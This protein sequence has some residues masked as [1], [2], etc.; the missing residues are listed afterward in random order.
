[1]AIG[2]HNVR[3]RGPMPMPS[4]S[5]SASR[6]SRPSSLTRVAAYPPNRHMR[7]PGPSAFPTRLPSVLNMRAQPSIARNAY[8]L[9]LATL[10]YVHSVTACPIRSQ[11]ALPILRSIAARQ[12][13]RP[14]SHRPATASNTRV[15]RIPAIIAAHR[16]ATQANHDSAAVFKKGAVGNHAGP[17]RHLSD[18]GLISIDDGAQK[19]KKKFP[20]SWPWMRKNGIQGD[21]RGSTPNRPRA[22]S[23]RICAHVRLIR[24]SIVRRGV[25]K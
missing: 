6:W 2:K 9:I 24:Q 5:V 20:R 18:D 13:Q 7:F 17:A 21:P 12:A 4:R 15:P 19:K 25:S 11:P 8:K 16:K 3:R 23:T 1:M 22:S 14:S 10:A